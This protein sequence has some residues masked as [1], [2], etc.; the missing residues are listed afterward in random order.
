MQ[1]VLPS[2]Q[3]ETNHSN[4]EVIHI[5]KIY[6][7]PG[8]QPCNASKREMK[9]LGI[10]FAEVSIAENPDAIG[11]VKNLGYLGA[12]VTVAPDGEHWTGFDP[13]KIAQYA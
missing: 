12:P 6:T 1:R 10:D 13:S 7:K 2:V 8:C 9:R 11:E 4:R 5:L 3:T